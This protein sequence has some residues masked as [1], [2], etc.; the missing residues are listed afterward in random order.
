MFNNVKAREVIDTLTSLKGKGGIDTFFELKE[1]Y[2]K[3]R[4][5]DHGKTVLVHKINMDKLSE[6]NHDEL[7]FMLMNALGL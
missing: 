3:V 7:S 1:E 2:V 4:I 6:Q 5:Q